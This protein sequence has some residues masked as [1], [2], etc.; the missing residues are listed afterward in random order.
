MLCLIL[1]LVALVLFAVATFAVNAK[2][3][4]VAAGLAFYMAYVVFCQ[5]THLAK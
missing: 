3:N 5:V 4:I 2:I 1:V